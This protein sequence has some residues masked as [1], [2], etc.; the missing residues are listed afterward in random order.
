MKQINIADTANH[1]ILNESKRYY[2]KYMESELSVNAASENVLIN[3]TSTKLKNPKI[4]SNTLWITKM[5]ERMRIRNER[6]HRVCKEYQDKYSTTKFTNFDKHILKDLNENGGRWLMDTTHHRLGFC[7]HEK[8]ASTTLKYLFIDLADKM[9][10]DLKEKLKNTKDFQNSVNLFLFHSLIPSYFKMPNNLTVSTNTSVGEMLNQFLHSNNIL[11][12]SFVKHPFERLVS[13]YQHFV[14][15]VDE[16]TGKP[17]IDVMEKE[18]YTHLKIKTFSDFIKL[19]LDQYETSSC[20][21]AYH[22]PCQDMNTHWRPY[23][24]TCL[25]CDIDYNVIGK[26]ETFEDDVKY[27]LLKGELT[28]RIDINSARLHLNN[29]KEPNSTYFK[30]NNTAKQAPGFQGIIQ[31]RKYFS[32]LDNFE[33]NQLLNVYRMDLELFGYNVEAYM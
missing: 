16:N 4:I 25:Y 22:F 15:R 6:I 5:D 12:F 26:T 21:N 3:D 17:L 9:A 29:F 28:D 24:P 27:I 14:L 31:H 19:V 2:A 20:S 13:N 8:V 1:P 33:K 10:P 7:K 23:F 32:Q 11:S 30:L 18:R